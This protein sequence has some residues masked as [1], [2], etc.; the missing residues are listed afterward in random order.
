[1]I[2]VIIEFPDVGP[3]D[4]PIDEKEVRNWALASIKST[5]SFTGIRLKLIEIT[6]VTNDD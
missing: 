4:I 1:M 2:R 3:D 6:A 5:E